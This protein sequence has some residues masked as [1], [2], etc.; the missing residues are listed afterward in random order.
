MTRTTAD[1][2]GPSKSR[3]STVCNGAAKGRNSCRVGA[4]GRPSW[5]CRRR[6][7]ERHHCRQQ[8]RCCCPSVDRGFVVGKWLCLVSSC[9]CGCHCRR[10]EH[11]GPCDCGCVVAGF[12]D[13]RQRKDW[14]G[15]LSEQSRGRRKCSD[16]FPMPNMCI[17]KVP[18]THNTMKLR[19]GHMCWTTL[20]ERDDKCTISR[21]G[22]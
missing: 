5:S 20:K 12:I 2:S 4:C 10:C 1:C 16:D 18:D 7:R 9:L 6:R 15:R 21:C 11:P 13:R 22:H 17:R 3:T 14:A 19:F 8:C